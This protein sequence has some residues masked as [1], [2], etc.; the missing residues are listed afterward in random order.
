MT[1]ADLTLTRLD[2]DDKPAGGTTTTLW[3]SDPD[4]N[5]VGYSFRDRFPRLQVTILSSHNGT[6]Y[7]DSSD[8][9]GD[10]EEFHTEAYV[11]ND[12]ATYDIVLAKPQIRVRYANT[13]TLS[14]WAVSIVGVRDR[15]VAA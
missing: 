15:A 11:A 9:D 10:W 4:G 13:G 6:L 8:G 12:E 3:S 1:P 2:F 14:E 7:F 5:S